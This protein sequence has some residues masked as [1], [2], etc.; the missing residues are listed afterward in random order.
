MRADNRQLWKVA[1]QTFYVSQPPVLNVENHGF[2]M[3]P[4]HSVPQFFTGSGHMHGKV[5][6]QSTD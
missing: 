3:V 5:S 2:W 6:A 1:M 4:L